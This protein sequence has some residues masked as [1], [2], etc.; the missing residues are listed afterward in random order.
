M[1]DL[2]SFCMGGE[3]GEGKITFHAPQENGK[4]LL[5]RKFVAQTF[6]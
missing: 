6:Q 1:L 4:T 3:E 5:E 2:F